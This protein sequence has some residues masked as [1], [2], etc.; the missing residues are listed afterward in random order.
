MMIDQ[1]YG[2]PLSIYS[3]FVIEEKY[4]FNKTT[5]STFVCDIFKQMLITLVI[6]AVVLPMLLWI[7]EVSGPALVGNLAGSTISLIIVLQ[8]LVPTVIVPLFY[9]YTDLE[10]GELKAAIFNEAKKSDV[11]VAEIKVI[12]GSKRSSHSNAFV[13]GFWKYRKVVIFDTLIE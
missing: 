9:T 7:I 4:G 6:M 10:D 3:T 11:S 8:L 5:A 13:S 1:V 2:I 12:D